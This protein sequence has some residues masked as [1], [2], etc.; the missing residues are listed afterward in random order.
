MRNGNNKVVGD[1]GEAKR[2]RKKLFL[3]NVLFQLETKKNLLE[4][5]MILKQKQY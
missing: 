3:K 2:I 1:V 5:M 4:T